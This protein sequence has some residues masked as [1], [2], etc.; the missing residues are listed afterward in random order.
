M[1]PRTRALRAFGRG[2]SSLQ[3]SGGT[4]VLG[5]L[6]RLEPLEARCLLDG[7]ISGY[8]RRD[9]NG[10]GI[11]GPSDPG[12]A[13]FRVYLDANRDGQLQEATEQWTETNAAGQYIFSNVP[14]GDYDIAVADR[15][16]WDQTS[17]T[18]RLIG[19]ECDYYDL[20]DAYL[21]EID[22]ETGFAIHRIHVN[23]DRGELYGHAEDEFYGLSA[24][25]YR[26]GVLY[27]MLADHTDQII[28]WSREVKP[29][30]LR[31]LPGANEVSVHKLG[32]SGLDRARCGGVAF[33]ATT[34]Q[35]YG[36]PSFN[37]ANA[38]ADYNYRLWHYSVEED[39]AN[40]VGTVVDDG[41]TH[42]FGGMAFDSDW[43][44][45]QI[46][47]YPGGLRDGLASLRQRERRYFGNT[48]TR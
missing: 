27:T 34:S 7:T 26:P 24:D 14:P 42:S 41:F 3:P 12:A 2:K 11:L 29:T 23:Y 40:T 5:R 25:P 4:P 15:V 17:P 47:N 16:G 21:W 36:G 30:E 18:T 1:R 22:P 13:G 44:L 19:L 46:E 28:T 9:V 32:D 48:Q 33:D 8:V 10:D 35:L 45:W 43:N 38:Q 31:Y 20:T 6:L 37:E 39:H